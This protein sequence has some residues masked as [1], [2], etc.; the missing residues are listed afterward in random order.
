MPFRD[1]PFNTAVL[2]RMFAYPARP[3][4]M[5]RGDVGSYLVTRGVGC[6][7]TGHMWRQGV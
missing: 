1:S 2:L 5:L 6:D 3:R 7:G 4:E